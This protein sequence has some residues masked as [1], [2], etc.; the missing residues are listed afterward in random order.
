MPLYRDLAA[1]LRASITSQG[2]RPGQ[3]LGSEHDLARSR[4]VSRVSVRRATDELIREGLIERRPGKGLFVCAS[5]GGGPVTGMIQVVSGNLAWDASLKA[6][7]GVQAAARATGVQ[8]QLYDAHGSMAEDIEVIRRLSDGPAAGAVILALHNARFTEALYGLKARGFPFVLIDQ[9]LRDL[10]V[11]AVLSD[12]PAGGR[13]MGELLVRHGHRRIAF[14]GDLSAVTVQERLAGLR[15]AVGDAGLPFDRALVADVQPEDP[16]ADW[17]PMIAER[18]R[19]VMAAAVPPTAIFASCDAIARGVCKALAGMGL[20]VP[21]DVS[22]V[23][24]DDDPLA[25]L[26]DPPLTTVRQQFEGMG[27]AAFELLQRRMNDP[28][29][30]AE[31]RALPVTL[32]ERRSLAAPCR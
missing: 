1:S 2:L 28:L 12:N 15:D 18:T 27:R 16:L 30:P 21:V 13:Q 25:E 3:L 8:V 14:L 24:F 29:A 7:R 11:S 23:G 10:D 19:A 20:R 31:H 22:V 5:P 32:V 9:R 17:T 4:G 6:V 26:V